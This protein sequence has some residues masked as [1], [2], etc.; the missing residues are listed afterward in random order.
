MGP[1]GGVGDEG[2]AEEDAGALRAGEED[3]GDDYYAIIVSL[4]VVCVGVRG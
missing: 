3:L 2:R 4:W 1:P